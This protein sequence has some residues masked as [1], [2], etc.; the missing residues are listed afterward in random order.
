MAEYERIFL[1]RTE[2]EWELIEKRLNE[3]SRST[4]HAYINTRISMLEKEYGGSPGGVYFGGG[5][6]TRKFYITPSQFEILSKI[7][8]NTGLHESTIVNKLIIEPLLV[9][10]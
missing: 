1:T 9:I 2:K 4:I 10:Q 8:E 5:K 6:K 7:S 3:I